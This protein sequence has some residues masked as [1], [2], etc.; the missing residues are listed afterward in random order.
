MGQ[1]TLGKRLI[2]RKVAYPLVLDP[3][4]DGIPV[5]FFLRQHHNPACPVGK[6]AR[7]CSMLH[8]ALLTLIPGYARCQYVRS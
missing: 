6:T 5:A 8:A 1:G 3:A 2:R 7:T 4:N